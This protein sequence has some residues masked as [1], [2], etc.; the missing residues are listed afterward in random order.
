M[1]KASKTRASL[2]GSARSRGRTNDLRD[3]KTTRYDHLI[4]DFEPC[5]ATSSV[6]LYAQGPVIIC[7]RH[8]TLK[9][10]RRFTGHSEAIQLLAVDNISQQGAGRLVVSYDAG[11]TAI[12]WDLKTGD[13]IAR[14]ASYSHLTTATWMKNGN[15]AFGNIQGHVIQ[16]EPATSEHL[17]TRTLSQ[18]PIT[19]LAVANDSATFAIG[20]QNGTLLVAALGDRFNV[21]HTLATNQAPSPIVTLQWHSSTPQQKSI[22]LAAQTRDGDL[23]VWSVPK[24]NQGGVPTAVRI[25]SKNEQ[26]LIPGPNWMSWS[27]NGR[28]IQYSGNETLS[29]DV[30]T[31]HVTRDSI[32]TASDIRGIAIY[33]AGATLFTLGPDSTIQQFDLSSPSVLIADIQHPIHLL[34]PSPPVSIEEIGNATASSGFES[35]N[36]S[37]DSE[38]LGSEN[39]LDMYTSQKG[40]SGQDYSDMELTSFESSRAG[41]SVTNGGSSI[42]TENGY[43][44]KG[45]SENTYISTG[46]HLYSLPYTQNQI[47]SHYKAPSTVDFRS[48]SS[49]NTKSTFTRPVMGGNRS[50][51]RSRFTREPEQQADLDIFKYT[52]TRLDDIPYRPPNRDGTHLTNDDLRRQMLRTVF[53]WNGEVEELILDEM[54]RHPRGS[55]IRI[56]LSKWI[57]KEPDEEEIMASADLMSSS[58]WMLLALSGVGTQPSQKKL[59]RTYITKLLGQKEIHAAVTIMLGMGDHID[60]IEVYHSHKRYME[61]L[62]LA[63]LYLPSVWERQ[64]AIVKKWGEWAV[65]HGQQQLAIRCFACAEHESTEPWASPSA[66][67]LSFQSLDHS[68]FS[69]PLSPP[70]AMQGTNHQIAKTSALK[71]IT[72]FGDSGERKKFF[73][74]EGLSEKTPAANTKSMK[75]AYMGYNGSDDEDPTTA[76]QYPSNRSALATPTAVSVQSNASV[77]SSYS[78]KRLTSIGESSAEAKRLNSASHHAVQAQDPSEVDAELILSNGMNLGRAATASPMMVRSNYPRLTHEQS[79]PPPR[80]GL[81]QKIKMVH[82]RNASLDKINHMNLNINIDTTK[83]METPDNQSES[84]HS[85]YRW[86]RR[87]GPGSISSINSAST[88]RSIT[89]PTMKPSY[90]GH[91]YTS[92]VTADRNQASRQNEYG[93]GRNQQPPLERGRAPSRNYPAKRSPRSPV[94]MSP[95]DLVSLKANSTASTNIPTTPTTTSNIYKHLQASGH[96][97]DN[98]S[99]NRSLTRL[100]GMDDNNNPLAP[101]AVRAAPRVRD[102]S[103]EM[104]QFTSSTSISTSVKPS[105]AGSEDEEDYQLALDDRERFHRARSASRTR[106]Y[107]D[108]DLSGQPVIEK[109]RAK[110][111]ESQGQRRPLQLEFHGHAGDL[112]IIKE[113][114]QRKREMA[115]RELEQRRKELVDSTKTSVIPHPKDLSVGDFILRP[116]T[117]NGVVNTHGRDIPRVSTADPYILHKLSHDSNAGLSVPPKTMMAAQDL[118]QVGDSPSA[119]TQASTQILQSLNK[120]PKDLLKLAPSHGIEIAPGPATSSLPISSH[121]QDGLTLLPSTVYQPPSKGIPRSQSAPIPDEPSFLHRRDN[122]RQHERESTARKNLHISR[123]DNS[124][125]NPPAVLKELQHLV[126]SRPAT[127]DSAGPFE[128]MLPPPPPPTGHIPTTASALA[129]GMIEIV[130]D[131]TILRM[132]H[133]A[134]QSLGRNTPVT[135]S[136]SDFMVPVLSAPTPPMKGQMRGRSATDSN[137]T[138]RL[139]K[140]TERLRSASRT[141]KDNSGRDIPHSPGPGSVSYDDI[142]DQ[143]QH[144]RFALSQQQSQGLALPADLNSLPTG[145][146][147]NEFF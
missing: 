41:L 145:M 89:K 116:R 114:R 98:S 22:M 137:I 10:E 67:Q 84:T 83:P 62:I 15:I 131:N 88:S 141:R 120:K 70:S 2:H 82:T 61:A 119:I 90:D 81:T 72:S 76:V 69:P 103:G 45:T 104:K 134:S 95:E 100:G 109:S 108:V 7:C 85:R 25:L 21:L 146:K 128:A 11:Q 71:L 143:P 111:S 59:G 19:A 48:Q 24:S 130:K 32:P 77:N 6:F 113:E 55:S 75:D 66:M 65:Q 35:E 42:P 28:I 38:Y 39:N 102:T 17:S 47:A 13:E 112:R 53:G 37:V 50:G 33:G 30:R 142:A 74:E 68:I 139:N 16:F 121:A 136:Q 129:T 51:S 117:A 127:K 144:A 97:T 115:A 73:T 91:M 43:H 110:N 56:I 34:P 135:V 1:S 79:L 96:T 92:G 5:A 80:A 126:P 101:S 31:R 123:Q 64:S 78:R 58:D 26:N 52:R 9:I 3:F 36:I 23:R 27:K 147:R 49:L 124:K 57:G 87:R 107:K 122:Y 46:T 133:K 14:F 93:R 44:R 106:S 99:R 86:P 18:I 20:Y 54:A 140:S 132:Q 60:A 125:S 138:G 12:V 8:Q 94:P 4:R 105:L 40:I 63:C 118:S 29:W